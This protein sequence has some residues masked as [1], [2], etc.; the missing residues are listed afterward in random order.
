MGELQY[1]NQ[2]SGSWVSQAVRGFALSRR[3]NTPWV[4]IPLLLSLIFF[5]LC[6]GVNHNLYVNQK[7]YEFQR[8][9]RVCTIMADHEGQGKNRC[10]S[11]CINNDVRKHERQQ[12]INNKYWSSWKGNIENQSYSF[13]PYVQTHV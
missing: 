1:S 10:L 11:K 7:T 8:V 12:S 5:R 13:P 9:L 3:S 4:G 6:T 2:T